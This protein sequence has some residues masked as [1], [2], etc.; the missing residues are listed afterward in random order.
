MCNIAHLAGSPDNRGAGHHMRTDWANFAT[1][2]NPG[3][4]S[5]DSHTRTTRVCGAEPIT[6]PLLPTA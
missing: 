1:T 2:G 5:Y 6:R 3:W 4:V